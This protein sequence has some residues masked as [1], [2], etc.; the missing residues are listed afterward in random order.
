MTDQQKL[1]QN[2]RPVLPAYGQMLEEFHNDHNVFCLIM[3]NDALHDRIHRLEQRCFRLEMLVIEFGGRPDREN[4][5]DV[6]DGFDMADH[7]RRFH[8]VT[9][10][11]NDKKR[12]Q[13]ARK[14]LFD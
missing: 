4:A 5:G 2:E 1:V 6:P 14:T 13:A 9:N 7:K 10:R 3:E 11:I 12:K 8:N